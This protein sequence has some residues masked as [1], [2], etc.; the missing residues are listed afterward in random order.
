MAI[1]DI[2]ENVAH[3][4][5]LDT[6]AD[7]LQQA[8]R[9][10]YRAA[11]PAG[12]ALKRFL[13]GRWLGHPLHPV[14]TDVPIGAWTAAL[15][16]DVLEMAGGSTLPGGTGEQLGAAADKALILGEVT[17]LAAAVA[18]ATDWQPLNGRRSRRVG[19][20][21][22][23]LNSSAALLYGGSLLARARGRRAM[24]RGLAVLGYAAVAAGAYL[25]GHL[26][27][28]LQ[29]GVDHTADLTTPDDFVPLVP[30]AELP[31]GELR[32][33]TAGRDGVP[34]VLYRQDGRVHALV[35]T[36]AHLGGPLA[37]GHVEGH[38]VVCPWHASQFDLDTGRVMDGPSAY[39]QPV[40]EVRVKDGQIEVKG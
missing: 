22:A 4:E 38:C 37:E 15:V 19:V 16:L 7:K 5:W 40:L 9:G 29:I 20:M 21:H 25:G 18:G 11:G 34:V 31:E 17:A 33:A 30:E 23:L 27:Y 35:E 2:V 6:P 13:H 39:D 3:Q 10:L 26:V 36:C 12:D 1:Q 28:K 24:G 32:R 8:V 14:L